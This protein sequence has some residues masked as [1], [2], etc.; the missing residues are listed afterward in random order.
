MKESPQAK[1][2]VKKVMEEFKEHK[3]HSGSKKGPLVTNPKQGIAIALSE[4]RKK[5]LKIP[6]KGNTMKH[7]TK[8]D[9]MDESLGMRLGKESKHKQTM[10]DRRHESEGAKK[11]HKKK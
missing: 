8:K 4:A 11:H 1:R 3:L 5:G 6:K 9:K 7:Q 2:K 10:K